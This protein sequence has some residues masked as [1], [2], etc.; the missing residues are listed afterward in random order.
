M[1]DH[2]RLSFRTLAITLSTLAVLLFGAAAVP[3]LAGAQTP[4]A[5]SAL[6]N[7]RVGR[8]AT[9]DRVVL[10]F[11]GPVPSAFGGTW[12]PTLI[13]DPSGMRISLPGNKFVRVVTQPA[14]GFDTYFGPR[15]FTT[16]QLRNVRA[17]A[18]AGDFEGVLSIGLG[19]RHR[20]WLHLFTLANPSRLVIDVG[21]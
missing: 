17:V 4:P 6:T 14:S 10:D 21:R 12:T 1:K 3:G 7:I 19:V 5:S 18:I 13:A 11:R 2:S 9:F 16:P 8:H 15:K 20:T